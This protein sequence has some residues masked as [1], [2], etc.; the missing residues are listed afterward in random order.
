MKYLDRFNESDLIFFDIETAPLVKKLKKGT[1]LHDAWLYKVRH[2]NEHLRK[3]GE[4]LTPEEYYAKKSSLYAVF[5]QV[6]AIVAGR[7]TGD[8]LSTKKYI[9]KEGDLLGN[10]NADVQRILDK[11]PKAIFAGFANIGFDQ[12]F[13]TKRMIV[14]QIEPN[15][16]LDTAG[17]KPWELPA[18]DLKD[19][20]KGT[21]FYPDSLISVAVA[22]GLPS[23]KIKME[24]E[25][26][27]EAFFA[28]KIDEIA[29][30]CEQ[31]V[32]TTANIFRRFKG[33]SLVTLG[34]SL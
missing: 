24:G 12:P 25:Q 1:P 3:T 9:G 23:P 7:I 2:E 10:F 31:N 5:S 26:V 11:N 32:L 27:G 6:V 17:S 21:G 30:Y 15:N 16:L 33:K 22:L 20:W 8:Q 34:R 29:D 13:L 4:E 18:I 28:G 19:L 14:N